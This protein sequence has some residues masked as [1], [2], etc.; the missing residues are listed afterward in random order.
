[1]SFG[2]FCRLVSPFWFHWIP[3]PSH[4]KAQGKLVSWTCDW[5]QTPNLFKGKGKPSV[6]ESNQGWNQCQM[7]RMIPRPANF[8]IRSYP[9]T[10]SERNR[11]NK[12]NEQVEKYAEQAALCG[13]K[14]F[15]VFRTIWSSPIGIRGC[16]GSTAFRYLDKKKLKEKIQKFRYKRSHGLSPFSTPFVY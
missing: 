9:R 3:T 1:M 10:S 8:D 13:K 4:S 14:K 6:Y 5:F 7:P 16:I 11:E 15:L 12:N 2:G